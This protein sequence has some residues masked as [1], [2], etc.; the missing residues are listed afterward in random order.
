MAKLL[1]RFDCW[2]EEELAALQELS[3]SHLHNWR[4]IEVGEVRAV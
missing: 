2:T 1:A 4:K 3:E